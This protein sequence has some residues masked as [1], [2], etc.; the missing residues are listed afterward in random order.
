[1]F[2]E[3][4]IPMKVFHFE[5]LEDIQNNVTTVQKDFQKIIPS[6]VSGHG[7]KLDIA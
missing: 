1:M 5:S 3:L 6:D 2:P 7:R 4:K